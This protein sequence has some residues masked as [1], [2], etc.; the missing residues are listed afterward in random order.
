MILLLKLRIK[1]LNI[2]TKMNF[3]N[4]FF[5]KLKGSNRSDNYSLSLPNPSSLIDK[6]MLSFIAVILNHQTIR[7][8][9]IRLLKNAKFYR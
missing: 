8:D 3:K 5:K 1:K 6:Q 4:L 9:V 2:F 7:E